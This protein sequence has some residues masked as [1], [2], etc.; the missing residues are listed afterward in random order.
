MPTGKQLKK[1][2]YE[3]EIIN[4]KLNSVEI[5]TAWKV[6]KYGVFSGLCFTVFCPNTRT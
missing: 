3:L 1:A 5:V 2:I 6:S 4:S